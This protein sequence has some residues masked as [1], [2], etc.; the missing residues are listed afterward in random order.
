MLPRS[1]IREHVEDPISPVQH[2]RKIDRAVHFRAERVVL[3]TRS[4]GPKR[5]ENP[6][7]GIEL[8]ILQKLIY[9]AVGSVRSR[10]YGNGRDTA[11]ETAVLRVVKV[12]LHR[13]FLRTAQCRHQI[14]A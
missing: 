12:R 4:G 11:A 2:L 5:V 10:F 9:L 1:L 6:L 7:G 8:Q 13:H 3:E 14:Y